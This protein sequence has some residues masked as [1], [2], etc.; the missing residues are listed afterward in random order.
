MEN[1]ILKTELLPDFDLGQKIWFYGEERPY[2]IRA[3]DN[4]FAICTKPFNLQ[5]TVLYTII[6]RKENIR[7]TENFIFCHGFETDKQC[8]DALHRLQKGKSEISHRNRV[9]LK[10]IKI[11]WEILEYSK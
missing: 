5:K 9:P 7:G 10:I 4:R 3:C 11:V 6:D 8:K 1:K 2:K